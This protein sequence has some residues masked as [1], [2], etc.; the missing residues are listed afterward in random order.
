MIA[1]WSPKG[2]SGTT[3]V[4]CGLA[5][6]LAR[7]LPPENRAGPSGVLLADLAGDVPAVVGIPDPAG[8]GLADWLAAGPHVPDDALTR[9]EVSVAPGVGLLPWR[10]SQSEPVIGADRARGEALAVALGAQDRTVVVDCGTAAAGASLAVAAGA[11]V[12]LMVVRPCYVALRR[13]LAAPIRPTGVVL[14]CEP[15]R[16]LNRR[17]VEDVLQVPVRA[18]IPY[19]P[20]VARLVDAGLLSRRVPRGLQRAL[21]RVA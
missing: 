4:S 14:V 16:A 8:S 2:G 1:C 20:A 21:E 19:D 5:L 11:A 17:D 12:S 9:L 18:E 7:A 6:V 13:A 15:G 3:V 10:G